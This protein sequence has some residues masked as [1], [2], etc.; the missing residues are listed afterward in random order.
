[1]NDKTRREIDKVVE[2]TLKDAGLIE[3]PVKVAD[4][5]LMPYL[6][7]ICVSLLPKRRKQN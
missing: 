3:P 7:H 2:G 1:M 4:R 5:R 6:S